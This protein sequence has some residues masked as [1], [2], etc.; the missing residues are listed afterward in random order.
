MVPFSFP[1]HESR[2]FRPR[3]PNRQSLDAPQRLPE[4]LRPPF[5][6]YVLLM[7][8]PSQSPFRGG[9][10]QRGCTQTHTGCILFYRQG[11]SFNAGVGTLPVSCSMLDSPSSRGASF[12]NLRVLLEGI[13][14]CF[15]HDLLCDLWILQNFCRS[16]WQ[17][18]TLRAVH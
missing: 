8:S 12:W 7:P 16:V 11:S 6:P 1:F 10:G 2:Q 18:T 15:P 9:K 17:H 14:L 3:P 4:L 5:P 13:F